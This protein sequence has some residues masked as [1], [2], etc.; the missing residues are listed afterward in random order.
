VANEAM[1]VNPRLKQYARMAAFVR[2]YLNV[3]SQW[4]RR[5]EGLPGNILVAK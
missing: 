5:R 1:F 4:L 3:G 2:E